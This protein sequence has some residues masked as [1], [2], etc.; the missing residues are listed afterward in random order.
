MR[1]TPAKVNLHLTVGKSRPLDGRHFVQSL[2][3]PFTR[4]QDCLELTP[5][6]PGT[7]VTLQ[8]SGRPIPDG[9]SPETNL[10]CRAVAAYCQAARI[11][12]DWNVK[13]WKSIPMGA[14]LGGGSSDAAA[15]LLELEESPHSPKL[16][17]EALHRLAASLG[18]DVSFF[19]NP[20]PS[21]ATGIG[22][23]L[24]PLPRFTPPP[25]RVLYPGFPSPV[26]W[27][28]A[29]WF[30]PPYLTPP[31]WPPEESTAPWPPE[32]LW[33]DLAFAVE[34]KYPILLQAK[35]RLRQAGATGTLLSGSGSAVLALFPTQEEAD[36]ATLDALPPRW[37]LL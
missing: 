34:E 18:A 3:V 14:G 8:L 19:L 22:E 33:N 24:T 10:A 2:L 12:P 23:I 13:L 11:P 36:H 17:G 28:Y 21:L 7:G 32:R 25:I 30:R 4:V 16:G 9:D 27:A 5:N 1:L 37:E 6:P 15:A 29:N 35:E 26:A 20:V 31:P